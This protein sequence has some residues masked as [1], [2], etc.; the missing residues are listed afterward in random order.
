[1]GEV[2]V[3]GLIRLLEAEVRQIFQTVSKS[4]SYCEHHDLETESY[5]GLWRAD[6]PHD[7]GIFRWYDGDMY[8]GDWSDGEMQGYGIYSYSLHGAHPGDR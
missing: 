8:Q 3:Y 2:F 6:Q 7:H 4:V 1:M 5:F